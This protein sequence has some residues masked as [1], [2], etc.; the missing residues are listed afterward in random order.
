ME[1]EFVP[2]EEKEKEKVSEISRIFNI[3]FEPRKV[4]ENLKTKPRWI[5]PFII[6]SLIG[7]ISFHYTYPFIMKQQIARIEESERIPEAQKEIII[8]R[9][10]ESEHPPIW[11]LGIAPIFTF[12]Y[13]L[14]VAAVLFFVGNVL[15]GGDSSFGRI[16][17]V[18]VYA[19]LVAI[20]AAIIKIPLV[21]MRETAEIQT[22]LAL[23]LS[24][25]MKESFIYRVFANFDIFT[26]WTLILV[27]IGVAVMYNFST[28]KSATAV[29]ILWLLFVVVS[30][31]L[32]GV[33]RGF[34]M[35]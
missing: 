22:S 11:Q 15:L 3:F 16:L 4:F 32:A 28:K 2:P 24:P 6:I 31:A 19:S 5:I 17:S 12:I 25:D 27:W 26:I 30:S 35:A 10:S 34:G 20:P 7:I 14:I 8:E 9:M 13:F 1:R 29:T 21:F 23:L 33:F 18:F